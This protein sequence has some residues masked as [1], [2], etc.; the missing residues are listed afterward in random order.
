MNSNDGKEGINT[1]ES[2]I[3]KLKGVFGGR[4]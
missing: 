1:K 4:V 3:E 2:N